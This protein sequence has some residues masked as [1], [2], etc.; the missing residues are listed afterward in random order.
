[1]CSCS[2]FELKAL[3]FVRRVPW[4]DISEGKG[5]DLSVDHPSDLGR[6][7]VASLIMVEELS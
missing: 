3:R 6:T 1:V 5:V 2:F 7:L 4:V